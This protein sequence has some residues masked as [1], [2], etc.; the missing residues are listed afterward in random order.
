[1][2]PIRIGLI[3][4]GNIFGCHA[5][6]LP[7]LKGVKVTAIA[8]RREDRRAR[9]AD[10]CP[11]AR[12]FDE[13]GALLDSGEVDAVII[14]TPHYD[15]PVLAAAAMERGVHVLVEKPV[16]VT[17]KAAQQ[18]NDLHA[19][20]PNIVYAAMFNQRTSPTHQRI[21][22]LCTDG[23][24]GPIQR[25][26]YVITT[27]FRS[28]HYYDSGDWRATW[29]G[30]GGGVLINQCPHNLDLMQWWVGMPSRVTAKVG[31]GK[32]HHIEVEDDVLALLEYPNGAVGTFAT[33]TGE[34][35]GV[36]RLE[37][38]GDKATLIYDGGE[39]ITLFENAT[40]AAEFCKT[41]TGSFGRPAR[42][43]HTIEVEG[44]YPQHRGITENFLAA[45]R[46]GAELI[47][48]A[49]DGVHGLELGNAMLM[50]GLKGEPIDIPTPRDEFDAMLKDL[51]ANSTFTKTAGSTDADVDMA[52]SF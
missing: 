38:V 39:T 17:A 24:L 9:G 29:S 19:R 30:E 48:P 10:K 36:S 43:K 41:T 25:V 51:A 34:A 37:V 46:E 18:I 11:D 47:A 28:Q 31:L 16:A 50:S 1:M 40:P 52:K 20:Y 13:G 42:H 35:P 33:T 23:T 27:W 4:C 6:Y 15:H 14:C 2:D 22:R 45:I 21:R 7:E 12:V 26:S 3:G 32:Y 49:E 5:R 8:D 44:P